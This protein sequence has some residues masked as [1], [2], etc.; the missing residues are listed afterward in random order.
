MPGRP[1]GGRTVAVG[2][3]PAGRT[4]VFPVPPPDH[5]W[6]CPPSSA[7]LKNLVQLFAKRHYNSWT[8]AEEAAVTALEADVPAYWSK[9]GHSNVLASDVLLTANRLGA[10]YALARHARPDWPSPAA[11]STA[12]RDTLIPLNEAARNELVGLG[13]Y[14]W[15]R[16]RKI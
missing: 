8:P 14:Q 2:H 1:R 12:L 11:H 5:G 10:T 3:D 16:R 9:S 6:H 13:A 15:K 7:Q 4:I